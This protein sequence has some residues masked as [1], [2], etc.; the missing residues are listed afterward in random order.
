MRSLVLLYRNRE[1]VTIREYPKV[2]DFGEHYIVGET[3]WGSKTGILK[4]YV[5]EVCKMEYYCGAYIAS[6]TLA[7]R[8]SVAK[9]PVEVPDMGDIKWHG[10]YFMFVNKTKYDANPIYYYDMIKN[11]REE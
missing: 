4:K 5:G 1:N 3:Y 10:G 7:N 6:S 9:Y 11:Y 8:A 2:E